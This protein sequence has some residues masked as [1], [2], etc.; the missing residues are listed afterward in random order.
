MERVKRVHAA[1]FSKP[2]SFI[3]S[4]FICGHN[5]NET[6]QKAIF[7]S[8]QIQLNL[9]ALIQCTYLTKKIYTA[10]DFGGSSSK[11]K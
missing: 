6:K 3:G 9:C 11:T 4:T 8:S 1:Q 7:F 10:L 2:Y 5:S